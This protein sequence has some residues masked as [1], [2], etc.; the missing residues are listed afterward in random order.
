MKRQKYIFFFRVSQGWV[1]KDVNSYLETI[2]W[3]RD[4]WPI[5]MIYRF[6]AKGWGLEH[7]SNT[8]V[9]VFKDRDAVKVT[10]DA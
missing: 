8:S 2:R 5:K 10:K 9:C 1:S 4:S 3:C 6:L 7:K